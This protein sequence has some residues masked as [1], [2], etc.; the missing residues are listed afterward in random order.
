MAIGQ[1]MKEVGHGQNYYWFLHL[2]FHLFAAYVGSINNVLWTS[3]IK[4]TSTF[5]E[6]TFISEAMVLC[7]SLLHSS[8]K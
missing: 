8:A 4:Y 5:K 3:S 2:T 1:Q 7:L 6:G